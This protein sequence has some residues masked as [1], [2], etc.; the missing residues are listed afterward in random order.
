MPLNRPV[1]VY[2][3][4][5]G[6]KTRMNY[7]YLAHQI[8]ECKTSCDQGQISIPNSLIVK[9][10]KIVI[11]AQGNKHMI[12]ALPSEG[13]VQLF[14]H[15]A[16]D[17]DGGIAAYPSVEH[18]RALGHASAIILHDVQPV[19]R[20]VSMVNP[21]WT[22]G[23]AIRSLMCLVAPKVAVP[24]PTSSG[25]TFPRRVRLISRISIRKVI[26]MIR[27]LEIWIRS[28]IN[29]SIALTWLRTVKPTLGV[30]AP[31]H[32]RNHTKYCQ[33]ADLLEYLCSQPTI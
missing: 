29:M 2:R 33:D 21:R 15:D 14:K 11:C 19:S 28:M 7:G 22:A 1:L 8:G 32:Y 10:C 23:A 30:K 18:G 25:F 26:N 5:L 12:A 3:I 17:V 6:I 20:S 9:C 4:M 31:L 13:S 27:E 24:L 16:P